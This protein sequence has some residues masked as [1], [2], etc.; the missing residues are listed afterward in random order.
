[1][2]GTHQRTPLVL[3]AALLL[4]GTS[5]LPA[6]PPV[7]SYLFPAGGRR[8]TTVQ[9]HL[10][11][12]NLHQHCSF[13][14]LGPGVQATPQL[15]HTQTL[16][17]EGPVIPLPDSQQP[18]DYPKDM[19]G[20]VRIAADAPLGIRHAR[21]WT[22]QGATPALKF[23]VGDLPE[24]VEQEIDGNPVP[25]QVKLPVTINGRIFPRE[26][27]DVWT[28]EARK[29]QTISGEVYAARLGSPLDSRLEVRDP[30]GRVIAE[31][32]DTF[33]ADS[34]VRFTAPADGTYQVRIHDIDFRG[35]QAFVYRL[36]LTA[37]P[38]VDRVFPLGGRRGSTLRVQ[39]SG[40][41]LA[42]GRV[43]I[44]LP[45]SGT[46]FTHRLTVAG[47]QT[48][49]FLLELD[50]LPE[51]VTTAP[52]SRLDRAQPVALPSVLNGRIDRPGE[53]D[54]WSFQA[55]RG[56][57]YDF[58][59]LAGRLGSPLDP[60]LVLLDAAGKELARSDAPSVPQADRHFQWSAPAAGSYVVRVADRFHSRGGPSHAY[61]L[62]IAPPPPPDFRLSVAADAVTVYRK[63]EAK[64]RITAERQ[65]GFTQPIHLDVAGLAK[66]LS[67]TDTTIP[68]NQSA[69]EI[70]IKADATAP[71]QAHHLTLRG[72]AQV[73]GRTVT[74]AATLPEARGTPELDSVLVAVA[75]PTPFQIK[76]PPS[77]SLAAR[78]TVYHRH[79]HL[80]RRGFTGPIRVSV[81][82]RQSR[83]LQ[84]ATGPTI[85]V[86]P[87]ASE[88]NYPISLPPWME[89]GRT[90]RVVV[91]GVAEL[92]DA[93]G[94]TH[95]VSFSSAQPDEQVIVV[96]DPGRL[97]LE[98]D[99][100][101][102]AAAPDTT[103]ALAVKVSRGKGLHGDVLL[104]LVAP[105][106]MAGLH[107]DAIKIPASR[108]DGVLR[109][110]FGP[111]P[112]GPLNMPVVIRATLRD[113][114]GPVVA[115]AKVGLEARA[116]AR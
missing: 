87:G 32:D 55:A 14:M 85:T 59:L 1:M 88:F 84:G 16:W 116:A 25:V 68:A 29:G 102:L 2:H 7:A 10:G 47:K 49:A 54:S 101:S 113:R 75:L 105:R 6:D 45:A 74:H 28:F 99:R 53:V 24:I 107:A 100:H 98:V 69:A 40:Q 44:A 21:A 80:E 33:G 37:D 95:T 36:T 78:G 115:E 56:A 20:T 76:G 65:G 89:T 3:A 106:H 18:E 5:P 83:H 57:V 48:N 97:A 92:K 90:C 13:E 110:R 51:Y 82:D 41:A 50:D 17:F 108:D 52:R 19:A 30:Q 22:S 43:Q 23:M 66:G 15:R 111:G 94:S 9:F 81:A 73:L 60:V 58:D 62:R 67:V 35:G 11:G 46:T 8:G 93:D 61:R 71:I 114:G 31:N 4:L 91:M 96:V 64:L 104:E 72:R 42:A 103:A 38:W 34:F 109:L 77:F 39:A 63:G 27:V 112:L 12:L 86:P 26:N 70:T 79:Y